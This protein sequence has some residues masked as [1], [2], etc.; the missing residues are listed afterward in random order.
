MSSSLNKNLNK[1]LRIIEQASIHAT[2]LNI[3]DENLKIIDEFYKDRHINLMI[4][5]LFLYYNSQT[6]ISNRD[7]EVLNKIN[8]KALLINKIRR[9][10]ENIKSLTLLNCINISAKFVFGF[11]RFELSFLCA[12]FQLFSIELAQRQSFEC[13]SVAFNIDL[14]KFEK[15]K[16]IK[17]STFGCLFIPF[18][19][20]YDIKYSRLKQISSTHDLS[21]QF[22][23]LNTDQLAETNGF[24]FPLKYLHKIFFELDDQTVKLFDSSQEIIHQILKA[25]Y[26]NWIIYNFGRFLEINKLLSDH[27]SRINFKYSYSNSES[28]E[29]ESLFEIMNSP[30]YIEPTFSGVRRDFILPPDELNLVWKLLRSSKTRFNITSVSFKLRLLSECLAVL[31]LCADC[32]ELESVDLWYEEADVE[33]KQ[34][35]IESA[36]IEFAKKFGP[37]KSLNIIKWL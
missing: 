13:D 26:I 24:I 6:D 25:R 20:I 31:T 30:D 23:G 11:N 10:L 12:P 5:Y 1:N 35:T 17:S 8:P 19:T 29:D 7:I 18:D 2:I 32:P 3:S 34:K 36:K 22:A 15:I 37:I 21:K 28:K 16:F 4:D 14:N 27:F 33:N 9:T